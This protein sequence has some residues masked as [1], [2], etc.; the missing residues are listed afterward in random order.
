MPSRLGLMLPLVAALA[1]P[2]TAL[3]TQSDTTGTAPSDVVQL[4]QGKSA[5]AKGKAK[6]KAKAKAEAKAKAKGKAKGAEKKA[7]KQAEKE[8]KKAEKAADKAEKQADK[9]AKKAEDTDEGTAG[10]AHDDARKKEI[11]KHERRLAKIARLDSL[12][13]SGNK[14]K[15]KEKASHLREL[16]N[17]R[18]TRALA[19]IDSRGQKAAD[20][21]EGAA[22]DVPDEKKASAG[23]K[24]AK[25]DAD[26]P[27]RK[28]AKGKTDKGGTR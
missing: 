5:D 23:D 10:A 8:A 12:A 11:E 3:A 14:D 1:L 6:A 27:T 24:P 16:E 28:R 4:A 9:E 26:K 22:K 20:A 15:L 13:N 19:R 25:D 17:K 21:E 7:E 18:H 2:G